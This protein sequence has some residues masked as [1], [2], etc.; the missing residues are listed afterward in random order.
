L[1]LATLL[2]SVFKSFSTAAAKRTAPLLRSPR[3]SIH[4][5]F[6]IGFE[7]GQFWERNLRRGSFS[8]SY[9]NNGG[10]QTTS[11][12]SENT[13]TQWPECVD[14]KLTCDECKTLIEKEGPS[15]V[16]TNVEI[17]GPT[18]PASLDYRQDRVRITCDKA[19][20]QVIAVPISG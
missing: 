20:N 4:Q 11:T 1:S 7:N 17:L 2:A 13:K 12:S 18:D 10:A 5:F 15:N 9:T 19:S 3:N 14:N 16:I 8:L 6:D